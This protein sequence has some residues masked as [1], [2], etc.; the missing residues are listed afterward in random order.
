MMMS[1]NTCA[2][3]RTGHFPFIRNTNEI[4]QTHE[5][6]EHRHSN[7]FCFCFIN[8]FKLATQLLFTLSLFSPSPPE[9]GPWGKF[10]F[11]NWHLTCTLQQ[12]MRL[13]QHYGELLPSQKLPRIIFIF[14]PFAAF[15][16]AVLPRGIVSRDCWKKGKEGSFAC[17]SMLEVQ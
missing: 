15:S 16:A 6:N 17:P 10:Q 13:C 1:P 7:I 14:Y 11:V 9:R 12:F 2:F 8:I 3:T 4:I 5:T